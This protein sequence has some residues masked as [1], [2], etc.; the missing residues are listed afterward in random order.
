MHEAMC[1]RWTAVRRWLSGGAERVVGLTANFARVCGACTWAGRSRRVRHLEAVA[2]DRYP[3]KLRIP[4]S[5][6]RWPAAIPFGAIASSRARS[7]ADSLTP[8]A[9]ALSSR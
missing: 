4:A 1:K 5:A 2:E 7:C 8:A 9:P 3:F 6:Y